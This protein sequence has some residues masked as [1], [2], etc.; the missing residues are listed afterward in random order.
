MK[1][2]DWF[3]PF[4]L[5]IVILTAAS[6]VWASALA[7]PPLHFRTWEFSN[8]AG[9]SLGQVSLTTANI[10]LQ[11][12]NVS[13][14]PGVLPTQSV[15]VTLDSTSGPDL[16]FNLTSGTAANVNALTNGNGSATRR[17]R[18]GDP[19][20]SVDGRFGFASFQRGNNNGNG[21]TNVRIS[22]VY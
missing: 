12:S 3:L 6:A 2:P 18:A 22:A 16:F 5:C 7:T 21:N 15:I 19:P 20:L 8:A 1:T 13:G 10:V 17:M 9:N 11:Q 4:T 14:Q